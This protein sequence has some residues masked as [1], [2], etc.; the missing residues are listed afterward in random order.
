MQWQSLLYWSKQANRKAWHWA[1]LRRIPPCLYT[2]RLRGLP[3]RG[4]YI[5]SFC[6]G[7]CSIKSKRG[8]SNCPGGLVSLQSSSWEIEAMPRSINSSQ[9]NWE[10]LAFTLES[11]RISISWKIVNSW[12]I[13]ESWIPG[14]CCSG[15]PVVTHDHADV[16][17]IVNRLGGPKACKKNVVGAEK[18]RQAEER[19]VFK[20]FH[21]QSPS[22]FPSRKEKCPRAPRQEQVAVAV[23]AEEQRWVCCCLLYSL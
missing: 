20:C 16:P 10:R 17:F 18:T 3:S 4:K 5:K 19:D 23:V 11:I 9:M 7:T 14:N 1:F 13:I 21:S 2:S 6:F 8:F 15:E 22:R 12:S